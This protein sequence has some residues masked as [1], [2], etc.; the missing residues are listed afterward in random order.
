MESGRIKL[1]NIHWNKI[2]RVTFQCHTGFFSRLTYIKQTSRL[3]KKNN[4][5]VL[6]KHVFLQRKCFW[7]SHKLGILTNY[8]PLLAHR[9]SLL[10]GLQMAR[11]IS[12]I[13]FYNW[14]WYFLYISNMCSFNVVNT[15]CVHF[16]LTL[17]C[18]K[19]NDSVE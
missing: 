16:S 1:S 12:D 8:N 15:K 13:W 3:Y 10:T 4:N 11:T 18:V 17:Y 6:N 9:F 2:L 19:I 5:P 7:S 14:R